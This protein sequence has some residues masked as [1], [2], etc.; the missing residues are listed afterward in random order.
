M[1][2]RRIGICI[3]VCIYLSCFL[4]EAIIPGVSTDTINMTTQT[5]TL[6]TLQPTATVTTILTSGSRFLVNTTSVPYTPN[7]KKRLIIKT[8]EGNPAIGAKFQVQ[9]IKVEEFQTMALN[10]DAVFSEVLFYDKVF[11]YPSDEII[12]GIKIS[13]P[14]YPD[15]SIRGP[16]LAN[17]TVIGLCRPENGK[18][19]IYPETFVSLM[20][21]TDIV[22][23][24]KYTSE[25]NELN[26][27]VLSRDYVK[28]DQAATSVSNSLKSSIQ[29]TGLNGGTRVVMDETG[30]I[31]CGGF[32]CVGCSK[33][34]DVYIGILCVYPPSGGGGIIKCATERATG[35]FCAMDITLPNGTTIKASSSEIFNTGIPFPTSPVSVASPK[36]TT[37]AQATA[38][39]T[40]TPTAA[41]I[42]GGISQEGA[43]GTSPLL[44]PISTSPQTTEIPGETQRLPP[45][46]ETVPKSTATAIPLGLVG[47]F[48]AL[49]VVIGYAIWK[50]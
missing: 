30:L 16:L 39:T 40:I 17:E 29:V 12:T 21:S 33:V 28:A 8:C 19:T 1:N 49:L 32:M 5:V 9:M 10:Y 7:E 27:A 18:I 46:T 43:I 25:I 31:E 48:I 14:G 41:S 26:Q 2:T 38:L 4:A 13:Y 35:G 3:I 24:Y 34:G 37:S 44:T 6:T 50:K 23:Q 22:T 47:I 36:P 45:H 15:M 20:N 42:G 11:E